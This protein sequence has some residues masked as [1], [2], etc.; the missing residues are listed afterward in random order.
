MTSQPH[1]CDLVGVI[2]GELL[3]VLTDAP[4]LN[5][6]DLLIEHKLDEMFSGWDWSKSFDRAQ[7]LVYDEVLPSELL[8]MLHQ[9]LRRKCADIENIQLILTHHAG[10][11]SWWQEWCELN[12]TQ[13][14]KIRELSFLSRPAATPDLLSLLSGKHGVRKDKSFFIKNKKINKI[15]SY[16]GGSYVSREREYLF[17]KFYKFRHQAIIDFLASIVA[18]KDEIL[19]YVENIT[20]FKNQV[21]IDNVSAAYDSFMCSKPDAYHDDLS[22]AKKNEDINFNA[23]QWQID[24]QCFASV[25]R[26]TINSDRYSC[27]TEKTIRAFLHHCVVIPLGYRSVEELEKKGFWFPHDIIDF[28]YQFESIFAYRIN[29]LTNILDV[30]VKHPASELQEYYA[31]NIDRFEHN[32]QLIYRELE[33]HQPFARVLEDS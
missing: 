29:Q 23:F 12:H 1:K 31:Q 19:S 30:L 16:Y 14:F 4:K 26:E 9:W 10:A 24:S 15:F 3:Q 18:S 17:L 11:E 13:S 2:G 7:I 25:V 27:V 22:R 21:E 28:S 32:A 8:P 5:P 33:N 20:Y 6:K